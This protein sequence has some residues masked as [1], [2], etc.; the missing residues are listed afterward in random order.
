MSLPFLNTKKIIKM[1][2]FNLFV[3]S[4]VIHDY[5][6]H[7][8]QIQLSRE[9]ARR[10]CSVIHAFAEGLLTPRGN[11]QG[12]AHDSCLVNFLEIPMH[13]KYRRSKYNFIKRRNY[14][15]KY[16]NSLAEKL[17]TTHPDLI[18]SA[19]T[20]SEPQWRFASKAM[21][22]GI[23]FISWTQDI[24]SEAVCRLIRKKF[25]FLSTWVGR[26]YRMLDRKA[27]RASSAIIAI[28]REFKDP[29]TRL[30]ADPKRIFVIPNWAP[31]DELPERLKNNPWSRTHGLNDKFVFLYSGTLAMKHNPDLILLL[32]RK[33]LN[34]REVMIVVISEGPGSDYLKKA[35]ETENLLNLLLL[36]YQDFS[37]MPDV[38]GSA[39]V[40]LA[41]LER[42]ASIFSVPSKVL[43]YQ[44]AGR[45]ILAAIPAENQAAQYITRHE[46][47]FCV[48]PEDT[49]GWLNSA[50]TLFASPELRNRLGDSARSFAERAFDIG[51]IADRF[52][53]IIRFA[54][55]HP[56]LLKNS[57]IR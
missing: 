20:P 1:D 27:L 24:Y 42:E 54:A 41:I 18:I 9:L 49:K 11:L 23:P 44:C 19:N 14:E 52:E 35:K 26:Y 4:I 46:S 50:S 28:S 56:V 30:G 55:A 6:G 21:L 32:A 16:G 25:F 17:L 45:P 12:K 15:K 34:Q 5:A 48:E 36:P 31:L 57:R 51:P 40:L 29:L 13:P 53:E 22:L 43:T 10:N 47:G 39:D 3:K 8:F 38:L 33:Y 7:P 2:K 37:V